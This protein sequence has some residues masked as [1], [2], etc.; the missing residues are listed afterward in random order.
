MAFFHST[1]RML[2]KSALSSSNH[3]SLL[4]E[5]TE[6]CR[7][8][9]RL[10]W[11]VAVAFLHIRK[12]LLSVLRQQEPDILLHPWLHRFGI[13]SGKIDANRAGEWVYIPHPSMGEPSII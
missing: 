10:Q 3:S 7:N 13:G 5:P 2:R 8:L 11:D 12:Y 9:L 6:F 4:W 1:L